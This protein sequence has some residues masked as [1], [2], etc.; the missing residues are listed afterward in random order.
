MSPSIQNNGAGD[1][2]LEGLA[3]PSES[4]RLVS[5]SLPANPDSGTITIPGDGGALNVQVEFVP[6]SR[7]LWGVEF[8]S[9]LL[10]GGGE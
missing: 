7:R 10:I 9:V 8:L 1:C 3:N 6:T 4:F 2:I 5:T